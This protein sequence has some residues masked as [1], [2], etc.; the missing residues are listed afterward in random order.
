MRKYF[1]GLNP[2]APYFEGWY[3]KL[4]NDSGQTIAL[5]PA[6]HISQDGRKSASIQI[7]SETDSWWVEYPADQFSASED[8]FLVQIGENI[9][10]EQGIRISVQKNGL[11]L[12]G[13]VSFGPILP[14][15]SDIMGPFRWLPN[16]ECSHSVISMRH[17][18]DGCLILNGEKLDYSRGLGYIESD[19]GRSFPQ[20]YLWTQCC[21]EE[22][23][24]MLSIASIP[25][26]R[27][28]FTGCICAIVHNGEEYRIATYKGARAVQW[29]K[30]CAVVKQGKY[31][32]EV[33]LLKQ[34]AQPLRAPADGD[35]CRAV[36]ES[37]CAEVHYRLWERNKI[38]L[39]KMSDKA[40][41]EY[42]NTKSSDP[43]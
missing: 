22:T 32:L 7:I 14:I 42:S 39:D 6:M 41:Y 30:D 9:F 31:R 33:K 34:S 3:F 15:R 8:R 26:S 19:R 36:H 23:S 28:Q 29:S 20:D 4:Q 37:L 17:R 1:Y 10:S 43:G 2:P 21:W 13:N 12:H 25:I 35:M 5:I 18:L 38:I 40:S 16:M 27:I 11:S 24:I